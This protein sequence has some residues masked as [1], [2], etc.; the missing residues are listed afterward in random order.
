MRESLLADAPLPPSPREKAISL[1]TELPG[2]G[3]TAA[4]RMEA[5]LGGNLEQLPASAF[6]DSLKEYFR[7]RPNSK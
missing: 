5:E 1:W 2:I 7:G 3:L 6:P 4:S